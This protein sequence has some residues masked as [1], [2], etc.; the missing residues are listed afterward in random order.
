[1]KFI[2]RFGADDFESPMTDSFR[3][4]SDKSPPHRHRSLNPIALHKRAT[5]VFG[6]AA[7]WLEDYGLPRV[8]WPHAFFEGGE[9]LYP[10]APTRIR[11]QEGCENTNCHAA[12]V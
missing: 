11:R 4:C 5:V 9:R 7:H 3:L 10:R 8:G 12:C 2:S 1:M 6:H